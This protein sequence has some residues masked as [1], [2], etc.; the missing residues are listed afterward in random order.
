LRN[1]Q[2]QDY[3]KIKHNVIEIRNILETIQFAVMTV[4]LVK[5]LILTGVY[6]LMSCSFAP[7][8]SVW[9]DKGLYKKNSQ[10]SAQT[11][12]SGNNSE[13]YCEIMGLRVI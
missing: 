7:F 12:L 6:E 8:H 4:I 10:L 1:L 13:P 11:P 5:S 9:K 3:T 2:S